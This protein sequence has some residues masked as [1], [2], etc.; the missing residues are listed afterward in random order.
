MEDSRYPEKNKTCNIFTM[1]FDEAWN[2]DAS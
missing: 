1:D 2:D